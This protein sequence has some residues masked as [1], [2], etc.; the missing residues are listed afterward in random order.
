MDRRPGGNSS[1]APK[2]WIPYLLMAIGMTTLALQ[3]LV[4]MVENRRANGAELD[5]QLE[6]QNATW[7][8]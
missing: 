6:A 5:A 7:T 2:L 8:E 1:W 4:Q 3:L